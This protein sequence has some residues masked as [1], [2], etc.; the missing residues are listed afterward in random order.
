MLY[1]VL[2]HQVFLSGRD[3]VSFMDVQEQ[4]CVCEG[5]LTPLVLFVI[6]KRMEIDRPG[7]PNEVPEDQS[8]KNPEGVTEWIKR[9]H[10]R[11]YRP[12]LKIKSCL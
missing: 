2:P 3:V 9:E 5:M 12:V 11:R 1:R 6:Y 7:L 4:S 8:K 10:K